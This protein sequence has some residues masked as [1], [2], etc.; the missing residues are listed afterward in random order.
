MGLQGWLQVTK[1]LWKAAGHG[2]CPPPPA[3]LGKSLGFPAR[4]VHG[5]GPNMPW[6]RVL[7][8]GGANTHRHQVA[9]TLQQNWASD[10][11]GLGKRKKSS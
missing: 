8:R 11:Q 5:F 7:G 6:S 10:P 9:Q 2:H 4:E 1:Q 3:A